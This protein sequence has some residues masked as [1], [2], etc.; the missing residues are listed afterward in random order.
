MKT[1]NRTA[2]TVLMVEP[3]CFGYNTETAVNNHFQ[4]KPTTNIAEIQQK[5]L[6]EF[7]EMTGTL[8]S[9]GI[10]VIVIKD[11]PE[12]YTPDSIFPNNWIS[13]HNDGQIVLYPMFAENR[14]AE[15][16]SDIADLLNKAGHRIEN[17]LDFN[18]WE[19]ENRFLEG[20]GSMILDR[21]NKIAY[22]SLSER[23]DKSL[24][25]QFCRTL[26]YEPVLFTA[27]QTVGNSRK[28]IYH[29][30]VAL[31]VADKYAVVCLEAIDSTEERQLLLSTLQK[32]EKDIIAIT[33]EQMHCFAGNMLQL[34]NAANECLLVMSQSAY[35]SL[36]GE[37]R[38]K[39]S[40]YNKLIVCAVPTIEQYG[41]G[42]VR[43]MMAEVF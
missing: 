15:R 33:E 9:H 16:R 42:S 29:T 5:A 27:C 7:R 22:A 37:Q 40:S 13:F 12:P 26:I 4:Q 1:L 31:S 23:T 36:T 39:L 41:G 30:N 11:T 18:F 24:F 8:R 19:E 28:A 21:V 35:D 2:S 38:T 20:T 32:T 3:V 17:V 14:R 25:L 10:E 43:C 6:Q 34:R